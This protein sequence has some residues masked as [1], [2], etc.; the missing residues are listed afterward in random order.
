[1]GA[2]LLASLALLLVGWLLQRKARRGPNELL[3]RGED[4]ELKR[5]PAVGLR[6]TNISLHVPGQQSPWGAF[7]DRTKQSSTTTGSSSPDRSGYKTILTGVSGSVSAGNML[8]ILG[9]VALERHHSWISCRA[10]T[11]EGLLVVMCLSS[12]LARKMMSIAWNEDPELAMLIRYVVGVPGLGIIL[13]DSICLR[14][15]GRCTTRDSHGLRS[16]PLRRTSP[17]SR[18]HASF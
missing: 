9:P 18:S 1:M 8:A 15:L 10:R 11:N 7:F 17:A 14:S 12:S 4:G 2:L 5:S 6:W 3:G 13:P 16:P